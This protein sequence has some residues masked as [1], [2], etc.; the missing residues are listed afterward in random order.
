MDDN[1]N[2]PVTHVVELVDCVWENGEDVTGRWDVIKNDGVNVT[3]WD[4]NQGTIVA[5]LNKCKFITAY[6]GFPIIQGE[7]K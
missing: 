3:L 6:V 7:I 4:P 5:P 2:T 1:D